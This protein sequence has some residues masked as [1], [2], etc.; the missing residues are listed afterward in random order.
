MIF[1]SGTEQ[2]FVNSEIQ[3]YKA[4]FSQFNILKFEEPCDIKNIV[5]NMSSISLLQEKR[6]FIFPEFY[7]FS[8]KETDFSKEEKS[9]VTL[10]GS[11][12]YNEYIFTYSKEK[13]TKNSF[14][15]Y[16]VTTSIHK[17]AKAIKSSDY[18][19][20]IKQIV[21]DN[22]GTITIFD[23][24]YLSQKLPNNLEL[25]V[26][27]LK[28]LLSENLNITKDIIDCSVGDYGLDDQFSFLN[29]I[30]TKNFA[31]IYKKYIERKTAGDTT[32]S[33][34]GQVANL[35]ILANKVINFKKSQ[36]PTNEIIDALNIHQFRFKKAEE[37]IN[38]FGQKSIMEIIYK[39]SQ[40][41]L[42]IKRTGVNDEIAF[43]IFLFNEFA[44]QV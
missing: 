2:Y 1:I 10:L 15:D 36:I 17:E 9:F 25:V 19:K 33:L 41:D 35:F 5:E 38:Q 12:N 24:L 23:A 40:I 6:L 20:V 43:E 34:I 42:D 4:N 13:I 18:P 16:V 39:L 14:S 32:L 29:S 26:S 28:K 30:P 7:L 37:L 31:F 21:N 11:D 27:E 44:K 3:R 22:N 8:K